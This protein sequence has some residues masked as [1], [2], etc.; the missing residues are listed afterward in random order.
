[1]NKKIFKYVAT[2]ALVLTLAMTST[3]SAFAKSSNNFTLKASAPSATFK[4]KS[5]TL[6]FSSKVTGGGTLT[7]YSARFN[8]SA[9]GKWNSTKK[10]S[11]IARSTSFK[12]TGLGGLSCSK[13][14]P[15]ISVSNGTLT[16][17]T[18]Y[19]NTNKFSHSYDLTIKRF[20]I[21]WVTQSVDVEYVYGSA[22][23]SLNCAADKV[24]W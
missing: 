19:S 7:S 14:G 13:S 15:S 12:T 22:S 17:S 21:C 1:M 4:K 9:S 24:F 5:V 10:C 6:S 2:L 8:G 11:S 18:S 23:K 3:T 16:H 20:D